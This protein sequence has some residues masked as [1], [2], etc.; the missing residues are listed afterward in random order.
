MLGLSTHVRAIIFTELLHFVPFL[1]D[2]WAIALASGLG[3]SGKAAISS[4]LACLSFSSEPNALISA[5]L[6]FGPIP[7]ISSNT[8]ARLRFSRSLLRVLY[9]SPGHT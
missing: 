5:F 8:E 9:F 3:I 4:T 2:R 6:R 1:V 7:G